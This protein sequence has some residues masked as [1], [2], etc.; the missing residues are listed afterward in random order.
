MQA[1]AAGL[2]VLRHPSDKNLETNLLPNA[3]ALV[4]P[5][6]WTGWYCSFSNIRM[7]QGLREDET[8]CMWRDYRK[9]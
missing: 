8:V 6:L 5:G 3:S 7:Q 9:N 1:S 2:Q 4:A